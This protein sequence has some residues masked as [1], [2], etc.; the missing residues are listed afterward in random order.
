MNIQISVSSSD[1]HLIPQD[2]LQIYFG[3]IRPP[4][5]KLKRL[6]Y[7]KEQQKTADDDKSTTGK[8][9]RSAAGNITFELIYKP[10]HNNKKQETKG[11]RAKVTCS[12]YNFVEQRAGSGNLHRTISGVSA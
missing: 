3:L 10:N 5:P 8:L 7:E 4:K 11:E 1:W 6:Q 12:L 9:Q 2:F